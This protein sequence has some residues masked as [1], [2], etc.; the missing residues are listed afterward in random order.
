MLNYNQ[1]QSLFEFLKEGCCSVHDDQILKLTLH[2]LD[3]S[4]EMR[5]SSDTMKRW[6]FILSFQCTLFFLCF[7]LFFFFFKWAWRTACWQAGMQRGFLSQYMSEWD[8]WSMPDSGLWIYPDLWWEEVRLDVSRESRGGD[9]RQEDRL[10]MQGSERREASGWGGPSTVLLLFELIGF[11]FSTLL[12]VLLF[13]RSPRR[14]SLRSH[15]TPS[16]P[17]QDSELSFR[18]LDWHLLKFLG[19]LFHSLLVLASPGC[20][21]T[22]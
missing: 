8:R 20:S 9:G 19:I 13:C 17:S 15:W 14:A 5:S 2:Q 12:C 6:V 18:F 4:A 10:P 16:H 21:N 11:Y 1:I 7:T 22:L 3:S